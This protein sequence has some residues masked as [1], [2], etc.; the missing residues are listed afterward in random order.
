M[1]STGL[2]EL[3]LLGLLGV[4]TANPVISGLTSDKPGSSNN[5]L[6]CNDPPVTLSLSD[7]PYNNYFY[8]DCN[9]AA[10]AVV[11]S[12]LPS[13][14]LS[15]IS[16]R[17][18]VA[19]PAGDSGVCAFFE[20]QN[21][22]NG[23][24]AIELV[25]STVGE[26]LAPL[27]H[28]ESGSKNPSVGVK[29]VLHFNSSATLTVPILGS[30]RAIRD[31]TE[32]GS[33]L[34]PEFQDSI[35]FNSLP[36]RGASLQRTWLDNVTFTALN[37]TPMSGCDGVTVDNG[38]LKFDAGKYEF[39]AELNYPQLTQLNSSEVLNSS[40]QGLI[41]QQSDN[42]KALTFLSYSEK[43]LAGAWRFLTY[44][45]RDSMIA[46]LLLDPVLSYGPGGSMEAVIGA[47]LERVN[48][49]D[50]S[51]CH[52]EVIGDYATW[53]NMQENKTSTAMSCDYKMVDTE[54]FLP[55][56]MQRYF[57]DNKVGRNRCP[58]FLN[59]SAG[60][61]NPANKNLTWRQLATTNAER[62]LR[63][64]NPFVQMQIKD[65]LIHLKKDQPVGNWRDSTYGLGAGRIPFDVN[66]SLMPAA[67]RSVAA[68]ARAGVYTH[69]LDWGRL[70]D[71]YAQVWEDK[72][73][74]FFE[75]QISQETAVQRVAEYAKTIDF[76]GPNQADSIDRDVNFYALALDSPNMNHN[77]LPKVQVMHTDDCFRHFL[78]NTTNQSQ[79]TSFINQT[80]SNIRR[81]FPAGL[82]TDAGMIVANPAF[83]DEP[84]HARNFT[85]GAYHGTVIWSWP[86]S[87]MAKG[88]EK[89]LDRC[90]E[91][92]GS[93][94]V[95]E[96]CHDTF[97]HDNLKK[98]YNVLWDS[99]EANTK[100]LGNEVWSWTYRDGKFNPT[101]LGILPAPPGS[102]GQTES[103]IRQLWSLTFLAV[104]RNEAFK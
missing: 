82:M 48:R 58:A 50:G 56:L 23:S 60:S 26:P 63:L 98:A 15:I 20:P 103:N 7:P 32:G 52:E 31:F 72:T 28:R 41:Q 102:G 53:T 43:L 30:I 17:L 70:A 6:T 59:T 71:E 101:P 14:N 90:V 9:V 4:S 12:P 25:N 39:S 55:V 68:L 97:V 1:K 24:L 47:V 18:I 46:A 69:E 35:Q 92:S 88:L 44:F 65:N 40:S 75:I 79:L 67:L 104:R 33:I 38:K 8:S 76:A 66:T 96:F 16:P 74:Q 81:T 99:I 10:Q 62:V 54:F 87:M 49:D 19:W 94:A 22:A 93:E 11:T 73:L 100:Q 37:F 85:N 51:V 57:V 77:F 80:A 45:G 64:A 61:I 5:A 89:Q 3:W 78:L 91:K 42:T 86:L 27:Y 2:K 34:R 84:V 95:P 29:G 21:G 83:G 36:G 13:S